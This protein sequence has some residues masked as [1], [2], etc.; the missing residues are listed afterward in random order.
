MY[1]KAL[2]KN[3]NIEISKINIVSSDF[4]L[5]EYS[6]VKNL[7][8]ELIQH[9]DT[10]N[11]LKEI[12]EDLRMAYK[13]GSL[14]RIEE[15]IEYITAKL[16]SSGQG[17][18][19]SNNTLTF[20]DE[21]KTKVFRKIIET[22]QKYSKNNNGSIKFFKTKTQDSMLFADIISHK[23]DIAVA[24][25][26]YTD[27]GS[28][29]KELKNFV[30]KNYKKPLSFY[31]NLYAVFLKRCSELINKNGKIGMIHPLTFMYIKSYEDMR[32]YIL[33]NFYI[34]VLIELGIGGVFRI[35]INVDVTM[36][37]L[38]KNNFKDDSFFMNLQPY[39]NQI[40]KKDIFLNSYKDYLNNEA[41]KH[42]FTLQQDDFR[43]IESYPFIYWISDELREKFLK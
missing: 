12:W 10:V 43:K 5:P 21:W 32:R 16:K 3:K 33:N 27:S 41:N 4:Y 19:W 18:L 28:Y 36:Y 31:S 6:K 40:N 38:E 17:I 14:I 15:K 9:P 37:I 24:N 13:F 42:N 35:P 8:S 1:I 30:T 22:L 7:F 39:K 25:P 34:N 23:Y 11:L 2:K 26:P 20:W 29:G